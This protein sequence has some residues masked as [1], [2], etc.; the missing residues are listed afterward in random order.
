VLIVVIMV[1]YQVLCRLWWIAEDYQLLE[2][3]LTHHD[4][5][6]RSRACSLLGNM[7]KQSV[8]FHSVLAQK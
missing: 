7:L 5:S 4:A 2:S 3:V 1:S 6:V 8:N